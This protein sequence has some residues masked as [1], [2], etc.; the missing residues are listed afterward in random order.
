MNSSITSWGLS[1]THCIASKSYLPP[2]TGGKGE[3][4]MCVCVC[5]SICVRIEGDDAEE[6]RI[7]ASNSQ[8]APVLI[9]S[10]RTQYQPS[11][12]PIPILP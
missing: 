7:L 3:S 4:E 1:G 11:R 2:K 6:P 5:V 8:M 9:A 12:L 10:L